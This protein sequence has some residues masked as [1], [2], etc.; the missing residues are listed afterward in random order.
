M[1]I[2]TFILACLLVIVSA[3][4][5]KAQFHETRTVEEFN[6]IET[7]GSVSVYF[8]P[9]DTASMI[10]YASEKEIN[11]VETRFKDGKLIISNKGKFTEPVKVYIKYKTLSSIDCSGASA[12]KTLG[13]LKTN[14]LNLGASGSANIKI[15]AET[16]SI[17][18]IESG[19]SHIKLSGS[20]ANLNAELSGASS[21]SAYELTAENVKVSTTGA[22][23][24]KV[25]CN[26]KMTAIAG[27]ASTIKIKGDAKDISAEAS[28]SSSITRI[29]DKDSKTAG[30][31]GDS[32]VYNWNKKKIIIIDKD[33]EDGGK[34]VEYRDDYF[35]AY[36]H[37]AGFSF[38]V[39]G[40]VDKNFNT[41]FSA[42]NDYMNLN[43][44]KSFN[45][46]FNLF[47]SHINLVKHHLVI[48]TGFG[49]DYH[50]YELENKVRLNADADYT[51]AFVDSSGIYTYKKNRLRNTYIQVPL[52]LEFNSSN[53]TSKCFHM[54]AGVIG[55]YQILSRTR[56]LLEN[57]AYE[58]D[59]QRKDPYNSNPFM[60][61]AHVNLGY[62]RWTFYGEYCIT[63]FFQK[64]KGPE[65]FPFAL[66][67]RVIPFG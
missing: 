51:N 12:F 9:S 54:A 3:S 27:G 15:S 66:G 55:Q 47:E 59:I 16:E 24:A 17:S 7:L 40:F 52:L 25:Y 61:K 20:T 18:S 38:G 36:R 42:P 48:V 1:R 28:P 4:N 29:L 39:N 37:W 57:E 43:Y 64:N 50:S 2:K 5:L 56:Q 44:A 22:S 49:F 32:T 35:N 67:L 13:T 46:Q 60:L 26:A 33:I 30:A 58:Y 10:V 53:K 14:S 21:L 19:A 31:D 63:P 34:T 23:S 6:A 45:Y 62:H 8:T 65:L 41:E 11:N